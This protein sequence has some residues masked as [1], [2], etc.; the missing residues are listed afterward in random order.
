MG[1]TTYDAQEEDRQA[2]AV[3][4]VAEPETVVG[5]FGVAKDV[6][7]LKEREDDSL[8]ALKHRVVQHVDVGDELEKVAAHAVEEGDVASKL[9]TV[10]NSSQPCDIYNMYTAVYCYNRAQSA[11][12][13]HIVSYCQTFT[14]LIAAMAMVDICAV[15]GTVG[16][17]PVAYRPTRGSECPG[18]LPRHTRQRSSLDWTCESRIYLPKPRGST[19]NATKGGRFLLGKRPNCSRSSSIGRSRCSPYKTIKRSPDMP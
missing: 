8:L 15:V 1:H 10:F 6:T 17:L 13:K 11:C 16:R 19:P 3:A 7:H 4:A 2:G 5:S 18:P 12:A 14:R 9:D